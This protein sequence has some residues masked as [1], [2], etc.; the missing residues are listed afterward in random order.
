MRRQT[1]DVVKLYLFTFCIVSML[2]QY[3]SLDDCE[4]AARLILLDYRYDKEIRF[5]LYCKPEEG[6]GF[7]Y[8][9]LT[10]DRESPAINVLQ[11]P[12]R[13]RHHEHVR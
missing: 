8:T 11:V 9:N 13:I 4:R 6:A 1:N 12:E 5:S 10:D 2:N 3:D 7:L